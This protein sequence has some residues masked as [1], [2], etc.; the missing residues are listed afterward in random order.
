MPKIVVDDGY[1][2]DTTKDNKEANK[3]TNQ[4]KLKAW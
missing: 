3:T 4:E 1:V 2:A